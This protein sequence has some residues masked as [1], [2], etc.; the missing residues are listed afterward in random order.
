[1]KKVALVTA[2][3]S[4]S[5]EIVIEKLKL[6]GFDVVGTDIYN[7]E[8]VANALD[9]S[10]FYHVP[11]VC[12]EEEYDKAVHMICRKEN[13]THIIPLTDVEVDYYNKNRNYYL[14]NNICI[15]ISGPEA[16]EICRDKYKQ[17]KFITEKISDILII[18]TRPAWECESMP[19]AFPMIAKPIDGRSSQEIVKIGSE[20][21]WNNFVKTELLNKYII[22][23]LLS[24][25]QIVTVDVIRQNDESVVA[26]PRLELLRTHNGAGLS[27]KVFDDSSL[28]EDCRRIVCAMGICGCV[29]I[30]FIMDEFGNY[31]YMECNPRFSAGVKFSDMAGYDF[32]TNHIRCFENKPID[33]LLSIREIYI[34]RKYKEFITGL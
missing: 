28:V 26:I 18:P 17:W 5:A 25:G 9:V 22:Q 16:I 8:Y 21:D 3:G 33:K 1:M 32:V 15:C 27:V 29:T 11:G 4:F 2:I 34:A 19:F 7:K 10:V 13:I 31:H 20:T 30:E 14:E 6:D 12:D 24:N 23:P